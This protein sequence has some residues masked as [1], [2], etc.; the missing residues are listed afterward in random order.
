MHIATF[1]QDENV[2][3]FT[4]EQEKM[5]TFLAAIVIFLTPKRCI[6]FA[7]YQDA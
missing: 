4:L 1:E 2:S 7:P 3:A 6:V 5:L